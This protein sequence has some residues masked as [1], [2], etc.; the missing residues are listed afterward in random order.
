MG[1]RVPS[2][3]HRPGSPLPPL[4][5]PT[6]PCARLTVRLGVHLVT[7]LH[8]R[9]VGHA[10]PTASVRCFFPPLAP[11][12]LSPPPRRLP[13]YSFSPLPL[14][15][16]LLFPFLCSFDVS[17][18]RSQALSMALDP[19]TPVGTSSSGFLNV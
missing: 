15:R 13:H 18:S 3:S 9:C 8:R 7:E 12:S 5:S 1:H 16:L 2:P 19:L 14:S 17:H 4:P 11:R 10:L 6:H